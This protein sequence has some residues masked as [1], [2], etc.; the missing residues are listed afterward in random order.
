MVGAERMMKDFK[1]DLSNIDQEIM[2][3][4]AFRYA[5]GRRSYV[6]RSISQILKNNWDN[7]PTERKQFFKNEIIEA[8]ARDD[9]GD[10]FIDKP[11]WNEIL[12]LGD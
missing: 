8:I 3:I 6:V 12:L 4:C 11:A 9:I 10:Q 2:L 7:L 1:L 5:L